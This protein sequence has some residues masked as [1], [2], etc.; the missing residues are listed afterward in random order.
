MLLCPALC[1]VV[2]LTISGGWKQPA[3]EPVVVQSR[4][5]Q[6][7]PNRKHETQ[8]LFV[9]VCPTISHIFH[10]SGWCRSM[11]LGCLQLPCDGYHRPR[12]RC[13]ADATAER[14]GPE[15]EFALQALSR[16]G[17]QFRLVTRDLDPEMHRVMHRVVCRVV[18][19]RRTSALNSPVEWLIA[20]PNSKSHCCSKN[21]GQLK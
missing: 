6:R 8:I 7:I 11:A 4:G 16:R 18:L 5:Y 13:R 12:L 19:F 3:Q 20:V 14:L 2:F 9:H 1:S 17:S 15:H 21:K 10:H